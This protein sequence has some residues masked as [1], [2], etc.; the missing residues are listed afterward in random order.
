MMQSRGSGIAIVLL[1]IVIVC[2]CFVPTSAKECYNIDI[3]NNVG[4]FAKLQNCTVVIGYLN[5]VLLERTTET[6]FKNLTFPELREITG[7]LVVFRVYGLKTFR[8][9]FPNLTVIRGAHLLANYALVVYDMPHLENLGFRALLSVQRGYVRVDKCIRLCFVHTIDWN[10]ITGTN[11]GGNYIQKDIMPTCPDGRVACKTCERDLCWNT[12]NCQRFEA[13]RYKDCDPKCLGGCIDGKCVVCRVVTDNDNCVDSCDP[14]KLLD[15]LSQ[16]CVD[17]SKCYAEGKIVHDGKCLEECPIGFMN[18]T[19]KC[20]KCKGH[21]P[22]TCYGSQID[23]IENAE[24]LRGCTIINGSLQIK[25]NTDMAQLLDELEENLGAIQEIHG[26]LKIYRSAPISSLK[27]LKNLH[28][29]HG[30]VLENNQ[31]ALII[32]ENSN[33]QKLFDFSYN[34]DE[35]KILNGGMLIHFNQ[36]L[37]NSEIQR[38]QNHTT[39]NK[40]LDYI[41]ADSNGYKH[42]CDMDT[43]KTDYDVISTSNV[44]I[45]WEKYHV[46]HKGDDDN[47]LAGYLIYYIEAPKTDI[48]TYFG[49]D[50]CSR[51]S[52]KSEL[53]D[54][55]SMNFDDVK[56]MYAFNLSELKAST[57]YA[58]YVRSYLSS[59]GINAQSIIKY[60]KTTIDKLSAPSV[61]T[62]MKTSDS[63]TLGWVMQSSQI[64]LIANYYIDVYKRPYSKESLDTRNYCKHPRTEDTNEDDYPAKHCCSD[65]DE[66]TYQILRRHTSYETN[67]NCEEDPFQPGCHLFEYDRF[68]REL[69]FLVTH[70]HLY[71][72]QNSPICRSPNIKYTGKREGSIGDDTGFRIFVDKH[73]TNFT[74]PNLAPYTLYTFQVFACQ[75]LYD[76]GPYYSMNERTTIDIVADLTMNFSM[77]DEPEEKSVELMWLEPLVPNGLTVAYKVEM[78]R[79]EGGEQEYET[80]C[81]M[82]RDHELNNNIFKYHTFD[83]TPGIYGFRVKAISV[84]MD[85]PWSEWVFY[86]VEEKHMSTATKVALSVVG[87][88]I[89]AIAVSC[90]LFWWTRHQRKS[91]KAEDTVVLMSAI[92]PQQSEDDNFLEMR[93]IIRERQQEAEQSQAA[94]AERQEE[95]EPQ[96]GPS[97]PPRPAPKPV[98]P[99]KGFVCKFRLDE[100][101]DEESDDEGKYKA[102]VIF[103]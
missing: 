64:P 93:E 36:K 3:R 77:I 73:H 2:G 33:L 8:T 51:H 92:E 57:Q 87:I 79:M 74:V 22:K 62:I 4:Q 66:E 60:F 46:D 25:L 56:G 94:Q 15:K 34:R 70:C 89:L 11:G 59:E 86:Y 72:G 35:M 48:T 41:S 24:K 54:L 23:F 7:M 58:F 55:S 9:L 18:V 26:F 99:V 53:I 16:R 68:K 90:G 81:I 37:C 52:W 67:L 83:M 102:R 29:I 42:A 27:F 69:E 97:R 82:R 78:R 84:A 85:G 19:H 80:V 17:G 31:F 49:R 95:E 63:V 100:G 71:H 1:F 10:K 101:D 61:S 98:S 91:S 96:P 88:G 32:Y 76:C 6:H 38:L 40:T 75:D 50:S 20:Q 44:T 65:H 14:P 43:I 5:I 13:H 47:I 39:Y 45:Y 21:C 12:F 103:E 30:E 28:T